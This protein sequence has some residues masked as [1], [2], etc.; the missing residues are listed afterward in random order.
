[1]FIFLSCKG[2]M[3]MPSCIFVWFLNNVFI[4][5][6]IKPQGENMEYRMIW[7]VFIAVFL[8]SHVQKMFREVQAYFTKSM[9]SR[10][11]WID[12][13]MIVRDPPACLCSCQCRHTSLQ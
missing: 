3:L 8:F 6:V 13:Q 9:P 12:L 4:Y 7:H 1:M 5:L 2:Y 10:A 11:L